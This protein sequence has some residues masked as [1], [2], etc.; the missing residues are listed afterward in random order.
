MPIRK[1]GVLIV[2][3]LV[4]L[5]LAG[6]GTAPKQQAE[7]LP[8]WNGE[9]P[10]VSGSGAD[11]KL[12]FPKTQA[13][14]ELKVW[15]VEQGKGAKVAATDFVVAHYEGQV[16]G[17]E[18]PFDSSFAR[19][20]PTMFSLQQVIKGWT[21]GL[22]GLP[23]GS[24]V[25]LS[26]PAELGYGPNG[27]NEGA[28]IRAD[29]VIAFYVEILD[30]YSAGEG[31]E[32]DAQL[33]AKLEEL[34]VTLNGALGETVTVAVKPDTA[35][36]ESEKITMIARGKGDPVVTTA[37]T[38]IVIQYSAASWDG[39]YTETTYNQRGPQ[40]LTVGTD[41]FANMLAGIPVGSRI[42]VELPAVGGT[43]SDDNA[44]RRPA[45]VYVI[46]ILGQYAPL[47]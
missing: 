34:P 6:C 39:Q 5:V 31:G 18:Q 25:V 8:A 12:A 43:E 3:A 40:T 38:T 20:A 28:G 30:A 7:T 41:E 46:D 4:G 14:D 42:M 19:K 1:I 32:A 17:N 22:A 11:V 44:Q 47:S 16:W 21:N 45:I 36:P 35:A 29:D 13:P 33:E 9:V 23:I 27:G 26:I 37:G 2:T 24:K 15:P 10:T